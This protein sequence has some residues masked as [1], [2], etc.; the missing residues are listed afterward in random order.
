MTTA[1]IRRLFEE[2]IR[3]AEQRPEFGRRLADAI[4]RLSSK[5]SPAVPPKGARRNRRAPGVLDPFEVFGRGELALR[6]ALQG[7]NVDQLKDIVSQHGM[8][9]SKLALKWRSPKRL[10]ELIVTTVRSRIEKGDAFKRDFKGQ[11]TAPKRETTDEALRPHRRL[12][13]M[14][15]APTEDEKY[16][17]FQA[18]VWMIETNSGTGFLNEDQCHPAYVL[19]MQGKI[20]PVAGG[21][22]PEK[23]DL[24]KLLE[25]FDQTYHGVVPNPDLST[26][27]KF[28][29]FAVESYKRVKGYD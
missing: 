23:N 11:D 6:E 25:S 26:W 28:C 20:D 18:L 5:P 13:N 29:T 21:D 10:I 3:E 2:I 9:A 22:S 1:V 4:G 17:I 15:S 27:Q 24:F 14:I 19:G 7:L 12:H 16:L 8:N